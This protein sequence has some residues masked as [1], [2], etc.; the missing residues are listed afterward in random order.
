MGDYRESE[1]GVFFLTFWP[2]QLP[3]GVMHHHESLGEA[4]L[5]HSLAY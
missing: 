5:Q 4:V 2:W 3:L 1:G